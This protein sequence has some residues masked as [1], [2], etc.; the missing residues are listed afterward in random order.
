[1][2]HPQESASIRTQHALVP[3]ASGARA[4]RRTLRNHHPTRPG[5]RFGPS[6][7]KMP[8]GCAFTEHCGMSRRRSRRDK[9]STHGHDLADY[10]DARRVGRSDGFRAD[11]HHAELLRAVRRLACHEI[12]SQKEMA[13]KYFPCPPTT[14]RSP[15]GWAPRASRSPSQ[16]PTACPFS[17]GA[18]LL[19]WRTFFRRRFARVLADG[20]EYTS[21]ITAPNVPRL[22]RQRC[23]ASVD[24]NSCAGLQTCH[25]PPR[26]SGFAHLRFSPV[27]AGANPQRYGAT[28][29]GLTGAGQTI[30]VVIDS[31]RQTAT[32]P[33]S[34]R[35]AASAGQAAFRRSR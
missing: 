24:C 17:P 35:D 16:S 11:A 6:R 8:R 2:K 29:T 25:S 26:P 15:A 21:A 22:W 33:R 5:Q 30:A 28:T 18:L 34:G 4:G 10:A 9:R 7:R 32:C 19:A 31:V 27:H 23:S 14:T 3:G 12:I 20:A 13:A 1:M